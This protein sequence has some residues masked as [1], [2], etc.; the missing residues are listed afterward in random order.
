MSKLARPKKPAT[1]GAGAKTKSNSPMLLLGF[2]LAVAT[3]IALYFTLTSNAAT[4]KVMV[5]A[6][7]IP[8]YT[9]LTS[10]YVKE[11]EVP[12]KSV[13]PDD[14]TPEKWAEQNKQGNTVVSTLPILTGQRLNLGAISAAAQGTLAAVRKN[15]RMVAVTA[16]FAG[17]TAGV[18]MPGSVV[19][20]YATKDSSGTAGSDTGGESPILENAKVLAVG[21]GPDTAKSVR[22]QGGVKQDKENRDS[23]LGGNIVVLLAVPTAQASQMAGLPVRLALDPSKSFTLSGV[24][25]SISKC[26]SSKSDSQGSVD[27][28]PVADPA[29]T[30]AEPAT[31]DPFEGTN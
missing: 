15:E 22:P 17:S 5:A 31:E 16:T 27:E 11:V 7:Q 4:S 21:A 8:P 12:T 24:V 19:D 26:A 25:C 9:A 2:G 20:V 13:T 14:V 6:K 18:A 30:T 3:F 28:A 1:V 29:A 23:G 10:S